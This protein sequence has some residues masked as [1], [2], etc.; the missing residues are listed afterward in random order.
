MTSRNRWSYRQWLVAMLLASGSLSIA[1]PL[2]A[3]TQIGDQIKNT[4]TGTFQD[5][6]GVGFTATSNEVVLQ[7]S[8]VAGLTVQA[9]APS[10]AN[11][12][13]NDAITADFVITNVG[14]DPTFVFVPGQATLANPPGKT[15]SASFTQGVLQIVEFGG[16]VLPTPINVPTNGESSEKFLAA[17]ALPNG[18]AL[19]PGQTIKVRVPL[20]VA[21]AALKNDGVQVS[22]GNTAAPADQQNILYAADAGS[23]FTNN[24]PDAG[25]PGEAPGNPAN[26]QREAMDTSQVITVGARLQAFAQILLARDYNNANTPGDVLDDRLTYNL[27]AKIDKTA[28][29]GILDV[30]PT[31]LCPTTVKLEGVAVDRILVSDAIPADTVLSAANPVAST[32]GTWT[33]VYTTSDIAIPANEA[34]WTAARPAASNTITRVGFLREDC[35]P[36]GSTI[37]GFNFTVEPAPGFAGGRIVNIAQIFGQSI[38]GAAVPNTATQ[39][40]YDESGDADPNN[41]L[42]VNNPDPKTGGAAE[43]AGG[44][45]A[46]RADLALDGVD[47]GKGVSPIAADTN[48][49]VNAGTTA[50][51][52]PAGGETVAQTIVTAPA[53]GPENQANANGPTDNEDDFTN[54]VL[55]PPAAIPATQLL[56]DEQTPVVNFTNT[57]QSYSAIPQVI[58]LLP[59]PPLVAAALP[60]GT[61]VKITNPV[62]GQSATY[63][64]SQA[65]GFTFVSGVGGPTADQ[66]VTLN[67]DPATLNTASYTLMVDLPSAEQV[68]EYPIPVL[69]FVDQ[70]TPGY[71]ANDPGNITIDRIY[72]GFIK[73]VKEARVLEDDGVKEVV[74]FTTDTTKLSG[75]AESGRFV[76]YRLTYTNVSIAQG[77]G[78][79]NVT[80]PA[81]DFTIV[82]DGTAA[83]NNWFT[84][85]KDAS[86]PAQA[87][88]TATTSATTGVI[89]VTPTN[90]DIQAY[91]LTVP[92]LSPGDTGTFTFRR[93]IA[94]K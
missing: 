53:N 75:A 25:A 79:N 18:G 21:N 1:L 7:V 16:T 56:N 22:L 90:G 66:P 28:P 15:G 44:I 49:G 24:I 31:A 50:G 12:D 86:F 69:A 29:A 43:N 19:N 46:R 88:G 89:S 47:P 36:T 72:T 17:N 80:L 27:A 71:D 94:K 2:L 13:P 54:I 73:V 78:L 64:Y 39:L 42:T 67:L 81:T 61:T 41:G 68:Q 52:K 87:N 77:R 35:I 57:V 34:L 76:E 83:P 10:K 4:F 37:S 26:G 8:E 48:Q 23:V 5:G 84:T 14:N 93:Q 62:N 65:N 20:T 38:A 33:V 60:D 85:T 45:M 91:K 40:V 74:P 55:A 11:P 30:V 58:S 63:S 51:T 59:R 70:G 9:Q 3:Q 6:N 32:D 82:D 92:G